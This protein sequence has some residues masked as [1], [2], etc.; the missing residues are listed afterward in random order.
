MKHDFALTCELVAQR[1]LP[2]CPYYGATA[3]LFTWEGALSDDQTLLSALIEHPFYDYGYTS[4]L[5]APA[6]L[7]EPDPPAAV[8]RHWIQATGSYPPPFAA[9]QAAT[10]P[11]PS[12]GHHGQASAQPA[13]STPPQPTHGPFALDHLTTASFE[14]IDPQAGISLIAQAIA[15]QDPTAS[16]EG[17]ELGEPLRTVVEHAAAAY[18]LLDDP[19]AHAE[20][21]W[22]VWGFTEVLFIDPSRRR[23][24]D[25]VLSG[26]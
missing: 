7:W 20:V 13:S 12:P 16:L 26:D 19:K 4:P 18:Q 8:R 11:N 10:S 3:W 21:D 25:V 22:I 9:T 6:N 1:L 17:L 23:L 5:P 15:E 24:L 14:R 2:G